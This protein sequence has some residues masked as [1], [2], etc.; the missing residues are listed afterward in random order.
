MALFA[1]TS[2]I[3]IFAL[4]PAPPCIPSTMNSDANIPHTTSLQADSMAFAI[5]GFNR[6]ALIFVI[7]AALFILAMF[8]IKSGF[9]LL[10]VIGKF[11]F[12]LKACTP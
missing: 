9:R 10:P 6:P 11:S 1:I 7:A 8:L 4:V 2:F 5:S 3:F 12:A